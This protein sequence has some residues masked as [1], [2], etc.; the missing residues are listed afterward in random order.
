MTIGKRVALI[1]LDSHRSQEENLPVSRRKHDPTQLARQS[2]VNARPLGSSRHATLRTVRTPPDSR[3]VSRNLRRRT[4]AR[5]RRRAALHQQ[6]APPLAATAPPPAVSVCSP[7][8]RSR[9]GS[10]RPVPERLVRSSPRSPRTASPR[11][12]S[13]L[14]ISGWSAIRFFVSP[15]STLTSNSDRSSFSTR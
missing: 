11:A 7:L 8:Y 15:G 10:R 2:L 5:L 12:R 14:T 4:A 3:T 13:S 9:P 6:P 1:S